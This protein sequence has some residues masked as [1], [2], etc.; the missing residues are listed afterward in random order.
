M[1]LSEADPANC[2]TTLLLR[3]SVAVYVKL[4]LGAMSLKE[5]L[6]GVNIPT[7]FHMNEPAIVS[8]AT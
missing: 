8:H 4:L 3:M 7:P 5:E 6:Q 2:F 1:P